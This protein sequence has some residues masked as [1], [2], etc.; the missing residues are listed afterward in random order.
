MKTTSKF[1]AYVLRHNPSVVG[2]ELDEHGWADVNALIDDVCKTGRFLNIQTI[3]EIVQ[4]DNKHRFSFNDDRTKI[5]ANQGHSIDVDV[6]MKACPPPDILY[7]GTAEKY[8]ESI[9]KNG[10]LKKSR[11]YVHLSKDVDT[12]I[13][14]GARHG[15]AIVLKIDARQMYADGYIFLLSA[16][17]VWQTEQVPF[18]YVTEEII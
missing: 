5:R 8:I 9:R 13:K 4:N 10:I 1:I 3:E 16:N 11:N 6:E 18:K 17:G 7:H 15:K 12:A 2:I 14:V